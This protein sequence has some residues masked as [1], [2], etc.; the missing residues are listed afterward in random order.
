MSTPEH[1]ESGT[2]PEHTYCQ[3]ARFTGQR[4]AGLAYRQ[5]QDAIFRAECEL[6]AFRLQIHHL[7][8]V[9]VV[10]QQPPAELHQRI[11]TILAA[12]ELVP[13]ATD[14]L[15]LLF[16]RRAQI[17]PHTDWMEGHYNQNNRI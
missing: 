12:G 14:I 4:P 13:L 11:R 10:G 2:D 15:A 6:S 5:A 1:E 9:A 7:W 3:A 8:H 17:I 16:E